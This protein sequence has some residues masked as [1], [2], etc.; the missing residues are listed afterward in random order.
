MSIPDFSKELPLIEMVGEGSVGPEFSVMFVTFINNKLDKLVSPHIM[1]TDKDWKKVKAEMNDCIGVG[2]SYRADI[3][4]VLAT[5]LVNYSQTYAGAGNNIT[6]EI[7]DR[8]I[9]LATEDVLQDD[10][11]YNL[12]KG[13]INSP[14]KDKF[15]GIMLNKRVVDMAIK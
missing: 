11:K 10:L 3:A 2:K 12:V 7:C 13:I 8:V 9:Q 5:R 6:K 14:V 15:K 4:S 1:L